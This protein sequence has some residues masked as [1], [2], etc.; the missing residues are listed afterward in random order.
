MDTGE[1]PGGIESR[2]MVYVF[3]M[4]QVSKLYLLSVDVVVIRIGERE[5]VGDGWA[6][7]IYL[8]YI[9]ELQCNTDSES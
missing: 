2:C 3:D 4:T 9:V 5:I 8:F 7:L 6:H 1:R